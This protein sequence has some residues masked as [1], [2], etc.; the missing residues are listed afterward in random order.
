MASFFAYCIHTFRHSDDLRDQQQEGGR[1]TLTEGKAWTTG[2]QLWA[3][4]GRAGER[5]PILFSGAEKHTG[6]IYWAT[7]DG[8]TIDDTTRQTTCLYSDLRA[9][10]PPKRL[11]ALRLRTGDRQVS[12]DLIRPYALCRTPGF[13]A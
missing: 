9:I 3:E 12:D 7:I 10:E 6:L 11:S 8:I 4:A 13:L 1:H 5:M 2:R